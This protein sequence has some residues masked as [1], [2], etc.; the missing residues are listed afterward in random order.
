MRVAFV[1]TGLMGGPMVRRLADA[2]HD[3]VV[4]AR[5]PDVADGLPG[6][7]ASSVAEAAD[8]A[9][10][11]CSIVTDSDDV[12]QVVDA[13]LTATRPPP[14]V[15]E[16]STIAPDTARSLGARSA[17]RGVAY[18]DCPV[19]GGPPGAEAGTLAIMVGGDAAA[20]AAAAPILDVLG[21]PDRRTHCGPIGSGLVVK[22]VNNLLVASITAATGEALGLA[23]EA[24]VDPRLARRV[25]LGATGSSWQLEH[26]FPRVL[27]GDHRPGFRIRDLRKDL[28]HAQGLAGGPLPIGDVTAGLVRGLPDDADYGIIARRFL[29]P[30]DPG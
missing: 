1:G 15:I 29:G 26:L 2:G 17:E 20:L 8:G 11:L 5:R 21:D 25:V 7:R 23:Q 12:V 9:D 19:S 14:L 13:A 6:A 10:A 3:V 28:G 22:L 30:P 27:A 16:M 4:Y 18:L 24:G